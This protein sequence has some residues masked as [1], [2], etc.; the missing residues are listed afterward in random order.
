MNLRFPVE[1]P[2]GNWVP[3][4]LYN[5]KIPL[6]TIMSLTVAVWD[7][8]CGPERGEP[9]AGSVMFALMEVV[10]EELK[11]QVSCL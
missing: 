2:N 1:N 5:P 7:L 3:P 6:L 8:L 10:K 9:V 4:Q 11:E